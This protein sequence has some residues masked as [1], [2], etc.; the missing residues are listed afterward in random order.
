[1]TSPTSTRQGRASQLELHARRLG[2]RTL[3]VRIADAAPESALA[4]PL[5]RMAA[6]SPIT[7]PSLATQILVCWRWRWGALPDGTR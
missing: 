2:Y 1:M 4:H 7:K 3:A 6:A 5:D